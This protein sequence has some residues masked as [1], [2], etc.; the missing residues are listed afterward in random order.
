MEKIMEHKMETGLHRVLYQLCPIRL[1]IYKV[2][3][4]IQDEEA[5]SFPS[6]PPVL[7]YTHGS[8]V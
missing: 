5:L 7:G 1:N 2:L 8:H 3:T 4:G 6:L